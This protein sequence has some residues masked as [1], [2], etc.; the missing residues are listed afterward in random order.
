MNLH[1]RV[2][3]EESA[4]PAGGE[5]PASGSAQGSL[6]LVL[7]GGQAGA[8]DIATVCD[9]SSERTPRRQPGPVKIAARPS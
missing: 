9:R 7:R 8:A 3:P 4:P 2:A 6:L 1:S 5:R